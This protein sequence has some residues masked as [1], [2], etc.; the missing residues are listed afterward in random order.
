MGPAAWRRVDA[1]QRVAGEPMHVTFV[2]SLDGKDY[3]MT[4]SANTDTLSEAR[5]DARTIRSEEKRGGKVVGVAVVKR[6]ADV[7]VMTITDEG[8]NRRGRG[9]LRCWCSSGR[10][11]RSIWCI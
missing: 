1:L 10:E 5:L 7:E 6:S 2:F 11:L 9:S 3:P 4:G 8:A